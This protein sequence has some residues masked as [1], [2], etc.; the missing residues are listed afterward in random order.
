MRIAIAVAAV[1]AALL[2]LWAWRH[3]AAQAAESA[4]RTAPVERGDIRVAISATGTLAAISTVDVGSQI[5]GQVTQV[6]VD[7]N[8][9]VRKG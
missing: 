8:A 7:Y 2:A 4:W 1:L 6:L 5:S 3:H 9:H